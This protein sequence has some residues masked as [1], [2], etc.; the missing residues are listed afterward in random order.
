MWK[1]LERK[2][3]PGS[4]IDGR[5]RLDRVK[6]EAGCELEEAASARWIQD[7]TRVKPELL[8]VTQDGGEV[9][10]GPRLWPS[11]H[12]LEAGDAFHFFFHPDGTNLI[13]S[14][15]GGVPLLLNPATK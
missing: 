14:H 7:G 5:K 12:C 13:C 3:F 4:G 15:H 2:A 1:G 11:E 6:D 10:A 8:D 9:A